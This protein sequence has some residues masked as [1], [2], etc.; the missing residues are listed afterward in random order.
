[1][2][3]HGVSAGNCPLGYRSRRIDIVLSSTTLLLRDAM[4]ARYMLRDVSV[5]CLSVRLSHTDRYCVKTAKLR[6]TQTTQHDRQ[7][8]LVF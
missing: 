1:M 6:I 2:G 5:L 4:P 3:V 8:D 7:V